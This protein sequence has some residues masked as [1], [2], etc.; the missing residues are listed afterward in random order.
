[1]LLPGG[2]VEK[3]ADAPRGPRAGGVEF[4]SIGACLVL[5]PSR[6]HHP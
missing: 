1:M 6:L 5:Y 4:L 3:I 2:F